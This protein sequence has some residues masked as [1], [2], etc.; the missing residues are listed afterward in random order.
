MSVRERVVESAEQG[1]LEFRALARGLPRNHTYRPLP[2]ITV[3]YRPGSCPHH[4]IVGNAFCRGHSS[5]S[6]SPSYRRPFF[7]T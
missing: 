5:F 2:S 6:V 4:H 7:I 3:S 1:G